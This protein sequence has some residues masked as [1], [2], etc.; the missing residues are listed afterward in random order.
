MF[1]FLAFLAG[2]V[3]SEVMWYRLV[4]IDVADVGLA[5]ARR[6]GG[7][8]GLTPFTFVSQCDRIHLVFWMVSLLSLKLRMRP[9]CFRATYVRGRRPRR[10]WGCRSDLTSTPVLLRSS[11]TGLTYL[12]LPWFL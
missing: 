1:V 2:R 6:L 4:R 8:V 10:F 11:Y 9:R 7:D 12:L 5:F 3:G